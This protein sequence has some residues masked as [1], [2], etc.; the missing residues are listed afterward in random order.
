MKTGKNKPR[1]DFS[2][3]SMLK[4]N[5]IIVN[6]TAILDIKSCNSHIHIFIHL[7]YR[8]HSSELIRRITAL[9]NV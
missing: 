5:G 4:S 6:W 8:V 7:V 1:T 3:I 9:Q 2:V